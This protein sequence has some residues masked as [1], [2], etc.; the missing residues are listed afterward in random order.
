VVGL[1]AILDDDGPRH[2]VLRVHA[3]AHLDVHVDLV[4]SERT[5][6]DQGSGPWYVIT[7]DTST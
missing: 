4:V 1:L 7:F 5:N 6:L 2:R 3:V